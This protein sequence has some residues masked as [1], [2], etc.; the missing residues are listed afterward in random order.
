MHQAAEA[1]D[2]I[3]L[4]RLLEE[5]Q[6]DISK[7]DENGLTP[8]HLA[9]KK[10]RLRCCQIL[11]DVSH[12]EINVKDRSGNTPLL[13]CI[14][15]KPGSFETA[16]LLIS[17][18]ANVNSSNKAKLTALHTA[19]E[20]GNLEVLHLLLLQKDIALNSEDSERHT[21]PH[22]ASKAGH[23]KICQALLLAGADVAACNVRGL[24]P[25]HI[26]AKM[27]FSTPRGRSVPPRRQWEHSLALRTDRRESKHVELIL[28]MA[29]ERSLD[30]VRLV[31]VRN[32]A[33]MTALHV[34][35]ARGERDSCRALLKAGADA[36]ISCESLGPP[37]SMA[38]QRGL[39][40]M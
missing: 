2:E 14:S 22:L 37:I 40:D 6:K 20:R 33:G 9:A 17:E 36:T 3:R 38:S 31:N 24:T 18:G 29:R 15:N 30:V 35:I 11:L 10:T 8:L 26:A 1:G 34:A 16:K 21:P 23:W 7:Q 4:R 12:K 25:L 32:E 39:Q 27:G 28:L 13:L 19:A 5:M